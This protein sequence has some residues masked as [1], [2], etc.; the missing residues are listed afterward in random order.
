MAESSINGDSDEN[1]PSVEGSAIEAGCSE[2]AAASST[3]VRTAKIVT[4]VDDVDHY[5]EVD[6][7][8]TKGSILDSYMSV[9]FNVPVD[10]NPKDKVYYITRGRKIGVFSGWYAFLLLFTTSF[11]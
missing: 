1:P 7:A 3:A 10:P 5:A 11:F 6:A 4:V 9:Y 2:T 8:I